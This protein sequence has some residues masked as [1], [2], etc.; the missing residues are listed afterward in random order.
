MWAVEKNLKRLS[1]NREWGE[2]TW[3]DFA[4][5]AEVN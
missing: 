5:N 4:Q 2:L 1:C 3:I